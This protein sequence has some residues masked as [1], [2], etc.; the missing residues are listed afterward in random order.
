M[1]KVIITLAIILAV[2]LVALAVVFNHYQSQWSVRHS[3][4]IEPLIIQVKR[5]SGVGQIGALLKSN[6]LIADTFDFKLYSRY[7]G[8]GTRYKSG[9]YA[10]PSNATIMEIAALLVQGKTA[11]VK[12]TIPE[13]RVSWEISTIL[14]SKM[15]QIDSAR[16]ETAVYDAQFAKELGI[17]SKSVEGYLYPD[18][19]QFPY[20]VTEKE[21]IRIMVAQFNRVFKTLEPEK[22]ELFKKY[23]TNG[24][25]TFASV[26]EEEA[27][28]SAERG[29]IAGVFYNR[30]KRGMPLGADPT[31]RYIFRNLTGPIYRSQLRSNSPFNTRK[32]TGLMPHAVSNPGKEALKA[33]LFPQENRDLYFVAKDN[34][35]M[36]HFFSGSLKQHNRYK[37]VAAANRKK[38]ATK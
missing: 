27:G 26:V 14:T 20:G 30:L 9:V 18:T 2:G 3:D 36:E 29:R 37:D 19:Y 31:V 38:Y 21:V 33:A 28:V 6:K 32:N 4:S 24:V 11:T 15:P 17:Q 35:S 7:S 1:K 22:S 12:V 10:I 34:G 5:G 13:G 23:G 25:V 16:F 8:L